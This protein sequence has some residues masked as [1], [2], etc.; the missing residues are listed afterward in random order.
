MSGYAGEAPAS[1]R[2]KVEDHTLVL[3]DGNH[4][5]AR[6]LYASQHSDQI[7]YIEGMRFVKMK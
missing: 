6:T 5:T 2:W 4:S 7:I 1:G 3:S